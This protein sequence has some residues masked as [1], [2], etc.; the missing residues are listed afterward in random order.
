MLFVRNADYSNTDAFRSQLRMRDAERALAE[1]ANGPLTDMFVN[2]QYAQAM[3]TLVG[4]EGRIPQDVFREFDNVTVQRMRLD[5]GDAFLNDLLP[6]ARA[7]NIGKLTYEYRRASD[8]GR[9][10]TSMTGQTGVKLDQVEF[11]PE[12]TIIPVHDAAFG[13]N[14]REWNAQ[15][16]EGFDALIDD[17][18]ETVASVRAKFADDFLDGH[19][20]ENGEIIVVDGRSWGGLRN[21]AKVEQFNLGASGLNFDFTDATKTGQEIKAALIAV[22]DQLRITNKCG[23]DLVI[24]VSKEI[25]S[26]WELNY[27]ANNDS[28]TILDVLTTLEQVEAIKSTNKLTGNELMMFPLDGTVK[29][30]TGMGLATMAMPRPVYNSNYEFVTAHASG[31]NVDV[32]YFNNT[33]VLYAA[34]L[35]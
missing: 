7:V 13:R 22:L 33:C 21:D 34:D 25:R 9:V 28:R 31:W 29:P 19:R 24:Y 14:W 2:G 32:D 8:S 18:R 16:S 35:G 20:D 23:K 10:Q 15:R 12:G 3:R 4:N 5:D 17:Q 6:L 30:I 26:N 1:Q 11:L 27:F